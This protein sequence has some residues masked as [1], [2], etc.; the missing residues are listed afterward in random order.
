MR[1]SRWAGAVGYTGRGAH[2]SRG[3]TPWGEPHPRLARD[4]ETP[5]LGENGRDEHAFWG[6]VLA[7]MGARGGELGPSLTWPSRLGKRA[8]AYGRE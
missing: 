1:M 4:T 2:R 6:G 7:E 5:E 8:R 3:A